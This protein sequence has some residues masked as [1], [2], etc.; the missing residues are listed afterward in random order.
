MAKKKKE[1]HFDFVDSDKLNYQRFTGIYYCDTNSEA[2]ARLIGDIHDAKHISI[3][4]QLTKVMNE[5]KGRDI[6]TQNFAIQYSAGFTVE[7]FKQNDDSRY[8]R[9]NTIS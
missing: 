6:D 2:I 5:I 7:C 8:V 3:K 4:K 1:E 9:Y